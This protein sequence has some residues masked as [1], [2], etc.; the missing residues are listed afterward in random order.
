MSF[1][2]TQDVQ[3]STLSNVLKQIYVYEQFLLQ[4]RCVLLHLNRNYKEQFKKMF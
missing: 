2:H 1:L 4:E 3:S